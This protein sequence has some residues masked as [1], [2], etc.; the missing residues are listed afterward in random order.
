[1]ICPDPHVLIACLLEYPYP[2]KVERD[3]GVVLTM[4]K[5]GY[6]A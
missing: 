3:A 4:Y 5:C 1:M 6:G 2:E